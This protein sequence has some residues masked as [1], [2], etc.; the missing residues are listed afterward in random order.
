MPEGDTVWRAAR[1]LHQAL[2]GEPL[3][4]SDFRVPA[5][6]EIDLR[7][8]VVTETVSRGKHLLT[9]LDDVTVHTHLRMEGSW[10]LFRPGSRWTSPAHQ[11]RVVLA[12]RNWQAVGF[13]L[14]LVEVLP[15][16]R[17]ADAVGHLGP[18]LLG[19]D[20]STAEAVK[21]LRGVPER[22][23]AEAL[24]DQRNLAGIGNLYA[25]EVLFLSGL[26]PQLPVAA[27]ESLE[28]V[29]ERAQRMLTVNREHTQQSTTG[30]PRRGHSH[31]VYRRAR[32]QCRRCGTR[33]R[34]ET[35]P[36]SPAFRRAS[37]VLEEDRARVSF[38][39]PACQPAP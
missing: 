2:S 6:A 36:V 35:F 12:N 19:P 17:E 26:H 39:C 20:W 1:R 8:R 21:R 4:E 25:N 33:I 27:V 24:L 29:V 16:E 9:R 28:A 11:A 31:F 22:P 10:H 13:R 23:I 15:R 5:F 3:T 34:T 32:E 7:G 37:G 38:W 18:D 30:D 14:G